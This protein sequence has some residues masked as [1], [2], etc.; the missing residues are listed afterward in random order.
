MT[1]TKNGLLKANLCSAEARQQVNSTD[2]FPS[3]RNGLRIPCHELPKQ[4]IV[5]IDG[6]AQTGKNTA[7][8]LVAEAIDGVLVDS[9]R[10]YRAMTQA[11]L[12]AGVD[13]DNATAVISFCRET[14]IEV[15][16]DRDGGKVDEALVAVSSQWFGKSDLQHV[17]AET[18]KVAR[19]PAVRQ[20]VNAAL[21][22]CAGYGRVVMLG[23][24][25][26]GVVFP[27]TSFKYFLDASE[28]IREQRHLRST[29]TH[30][31]VQ[32]DLQDQK[33]TTFAVDALLIDTGKL[34][35]TEVRAIIM[36]SLL[37]RAAQPLPAIR[38]ECAGAQ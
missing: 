5:A 31:A 18:P 26:G 37:C 15:R 27:E 14:T 19:L 2:T 32:R 25:I 34:E 21:R 1:D 38:K 35:P 20:V 12:N 36:R 29:Q 17:G 8:E 4:M 11:C 3:V 16:M 13:L 9:G 33:Q 24:D 22:L 30:G 6:W 10:F 23:R 28:E 7:G